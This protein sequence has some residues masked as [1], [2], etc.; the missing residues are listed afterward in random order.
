MRSRRWP[1]SVATVLC[2][3]GCLGDPVGPGGTI[4]LRSMTESRDSVIVGAPGRALVTPIT[5]EAVDGN[6]RP[7]VGAAVSWTLV[8]RNA[9]VENAD[10]VTAPDGRLEVTWVLGTSKRPSGAVTVSA[11]ST[12]ALRDRK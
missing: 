6:G 11:F 5:L 8:G 10:K 7:V 4:V 2:L 3:A 9:R 1:I 12:R